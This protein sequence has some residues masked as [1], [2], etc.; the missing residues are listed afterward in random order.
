M[1]HYTNID[2][3]ALPQNLLAHYYRALFKVTV[4][5]QES[6]DLVQS[7]RACLIDISPR[8]SEN[9]TQVIRNHGSTTHEI[10]FHYVAA[11][12]DGNWDYINKILLPRLFKQ[13]RCYALF[14]Q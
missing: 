11:P 8:Y 5:N 1:T 14:S 13:H 12:R 3:T 2:I 10:H 6:P 9:L 7:K 4:Q